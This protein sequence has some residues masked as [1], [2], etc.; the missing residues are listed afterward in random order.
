MAGTDTSVERRRVL[1]AEDDLASGESLRRELVRLGHQPVGPAPDAATAMDL[2]VRL[3]PDIALVSIPF[4]DVAA[5]V[6]LGK[7]LAGRG[8][9]VVFVAASR[10]GESLAA[11]AEARPYGLLLKPLDPYQL[12][13]SLEGALRLRAE[14]QLADRC[15][16]LSESERRFRAVFEQAGI[17]VNR[18]TPDGRYL[19]VNE[20]FARMVGRPALEL[21]GRAHA[22]ISHPDEREGDRTALAGLLAGREDSVVREKRYL[23]PDGTEVWARVNVTAVRDPEGRPE[24]LLAVAED[25]TDRRRTETELNNQLSFQRSLMDAAVNPIY[26][27]DPAGHYVSLNRAFETFLGVS[28][29]SALGLTARE[30]F[31]EEV[32]E[33]L[34][35]KDR[36]ILETDGVQ[37]FEIALENASGRER[38]LVLN[39]ARFDDA[40]GRPQGIVGVATDVTDSKRVEKDLRDEQEVLRRILTGV[41]AGIFII[42]PKTRIIEDVNP[43]AEELCGQSREQLLGKSC[44]VIDWSDQGGRR[45]TACVLAERNLVNEEMRLTRPDGRT[46]PIIKTVVAAM[47]R[48]KLK[49]FEIVFDISERK[50]LE[51][52]LAVAQKLESVGELAAGIA[53]EINTPTQYIGDNLHF[54][55]TAFA[56]LAAALEKTTALAGELARTAGD[57]EAATAIEAARREADVDFLLDEAPRALEQSVEGVARVTAIVSAM[58]KFS[59]PGGEDKV[60]VDINAAVENTVI[61]AKNEW[62][63]VADLSLDLDRTLP[64][65]F[66]LPGDFNQVLLNILVNAAHAIADKVKGT[67]EKGVITIRT[68]ADG[69]FLKLTVA[70]TGAGIP[71]ANRRKIF[72]PFFTTKE[73]GKGT[74]QGL[75]I[76]HNIVVSKH[77]GSID[78]DSEAGRGTTFVV[79][80][81][82]GGGEGDGTA[83]LAAGEEPL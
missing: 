34:A 65:V 51:R 21:V 74:G 2:A 60:A 14:E 46:V 52:Q 47:R 25:I 41:Q 63:Y 24:C 70:D 32:G 77:G 40:E 72:D 50:T 1:V 31:S 83:G 6:A 28:I 57:A 15:R 59:H 8:I 4:P 11:L 35:E 38:H 33:F 44:G 68:E 66:C 12:A 73:V 13:V 45:I 49:L 9:P 26:V 71:E 56:G 39:R 42:D 81:P 62:K 27:Q 17:G 55:S 48:G 29:Q 3:A 64:P 36:E 79:R 5:G 23:R 76:T 30:I 75:A 7:A 16:D 22:D 61:V 82:F 19:E 78:F 69:E 18:Q 37:Q 54:L 20:R 80:V 58:K 10:D 67:A 43:V 53:H